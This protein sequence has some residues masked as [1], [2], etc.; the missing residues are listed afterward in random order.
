MSLTFPQRSHTVGPTRNLSGGPK[1]LKVQIE[2][3]QCATTSLS[4]C[5]FCRRSKGSHKL[6][7]Q[8]YLNN[9]ANP[10]GHVAR[11]FVNLGG[12]ESTMCLGRKRRRASKGS[13]WQQKDQVRSQLKP[14]NRS[15]TDSSDLLWSLFPS[16]MGQKPSPPPFHLHYYH[17]SSSAECFS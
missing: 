10:S 12:D 1:K 6:P 17:L 8:V 9:T 4:P 13:K 16:P 3:V 2:G 15:P 11:S 5:L 7:V 14:T